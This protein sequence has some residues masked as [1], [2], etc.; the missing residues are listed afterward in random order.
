METKIRELDASETRWLEDRRAALAEAG[1]ASDLKALGRL[2]D[3]EL[4]AWL[5]ASRRQRPDPQPSAD[6]I[7]VGLGD[8]A[9]A[10]CGLRWVHITDAWGEQ[11]A[12]HRDD[13]VTFYPFDMIRKRWTS[14][15]L[16]GLPSLARAMVGAV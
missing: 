7:G 5:A 4:G 16:G 15:E 2:F 10:E 3:R 9:V 6:A 11:M 14:D 12:V 8:Y 1:A 13:G